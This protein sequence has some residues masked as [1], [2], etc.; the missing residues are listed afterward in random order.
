M[1]ISSGSPT[2]G[3]FERVVH[4]TPMM[5]NDEAEKKYS[6]TLDFRNIFL[7]KTTNI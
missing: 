2:T 7:I 4:N 1:T 3:V 5:L 6:H